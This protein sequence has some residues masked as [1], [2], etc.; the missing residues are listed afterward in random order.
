MILILYKCQCLPAE[1][2]V[3]I[4]P[5]RADEAIA[6]WMQNC[7][8][9]ALYLD[10]RKYSPDCRETEMEYVKIPSPDNAPFLGATPV[11]N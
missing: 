9:A 1:R 7:V 3:E 11:V 2:T 4:L 5:R 8:G 6:F 10:H